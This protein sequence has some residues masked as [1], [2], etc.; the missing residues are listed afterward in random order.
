MTLWKI[1]NKNFGSSRVAL[2]DLYIK[3]RTL[4]LVWNV[5]ISEDTDV[6][7]VGPG[8]PLSRERDGVI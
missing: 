1:G 3:E 2:S 6:R 8:D 4:H 5:D 7:E